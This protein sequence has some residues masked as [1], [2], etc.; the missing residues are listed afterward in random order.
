MAIILEDEYP[1]RVSPATEN[2]PL[3]SPR[4]NDAG[5]GTGTLFDAEMFKDIFGFFQ[6]LITKA[7]ITPSGVPDTALASDY[8]DSLPGLI[9]SGTNANGSYVRFSDG[10]QLH[11]GK[12]SV[13]CDTAAENLFGSTSGTTYVGDSGLIPYSA[14]FDGA[15]SLV[16]GANGSGVGFGGKAGVVSGGVSYSAT[17]HSQNLN[18]VVELGVHAIGRWAPPVFVNL[19]TN[20]YL[21]EM[22][23]PDGAQGSD[24]TYDPATDE[25]FVT[26]YD[27]D[28]TYVYTAATGVLVRTLS[29]GGRAIDFFEDLLWVSKSNGFTE[30]IY[31]TH[32]SGNPIYDGLPTS[33]HSYGGIFDA[34]IV[35]PINFISDGTSQYYALYNPS[36][37]PLQTVKKVGSL[38][39]ADD[40]PSYSF[41]AAQSFL[42]VDGHSY[43][44]FVDFGAD[45]LIK[46]GIDGPVVHSFESAA[47][48]S[49]LYWGGV[50][51][52]GEYLWSVT[53]GV[54]R[55]HDN[56]LVEI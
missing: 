18:D 16:V 1:G 41:A 40:T 6:A 3:G 52:A 45:T 11:S 2:Y 25:L 31:C 33:C 10:T 14:K 7:G 13:T 19:P 5:R 49:E 23:L 53:G 12:I 30:A 34:S 20:V 55:Q 22:T 48:V 50:A 43:F 27:E 15:P 42:F 26:D 8:Y 32:T 28:K 54:L 37:N 38:A 56:V 51:Q 4:N 29:F 21:Q 17:A 47:P 9:D 35:A 46:D 44:A 39:T 24:I 36:N